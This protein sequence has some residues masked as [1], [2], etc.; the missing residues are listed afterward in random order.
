MMEVRIKRG[1][2]D[3]VV[4]GISRT[5]KSSEENPVGIIIDVYGNDRL[6]S[7]QTH[8]F[9]DLLDKEDK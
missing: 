7:T 9:D 1:G 5:W 2:F 3:I 8:W 6:F 4:K